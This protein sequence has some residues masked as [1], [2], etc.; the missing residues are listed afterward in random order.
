MLGERFHLETP[1]RRKV[2]PK[3]SLSWSL[4]AYPSKGFYGSQTEMVSVTGIQTQQGTNI[5][6]LSSSL[7]SG[8]HVSL[9]PGSFRSPGRGDGKLGTGSRAPRPGP[10]RGGV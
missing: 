5:R 10:G 7:V 4:E 6:S 8:R 2:G 3:P 1:L 9:S